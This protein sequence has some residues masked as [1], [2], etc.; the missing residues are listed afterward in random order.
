V[1]RRPNG[2]MGVDDGGAIIDVR[3]WEFGASTTGELVVEG[4]V[5]CGR[6]QG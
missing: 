4:G 5:A 6:E 1:R 2:L 3:I